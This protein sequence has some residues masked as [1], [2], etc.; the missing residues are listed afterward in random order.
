MSRGWVVYILMFVIAAGG[1][2]VILILGRAA[3][4]PDDLSGNWTVEW[5]TAPPPKSDPPGEPAR[6]Q[7]AHSGRFFMVQF[8]E[9]EPLR[10]TLQP[11]WRGKRIGRLL[12]MKLAGGPWRLDLHG[13][14]PAAER[15]RVPE[16][17]LELVGPTRHV[18][19][20]RREPEQ[21]ADV[22]P[23]TSDL[24]AAAPATQP[25]DGP[26]IQPTAPTA[27]ATA[28]PAHAR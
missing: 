19:I 15:F 28:E 11:G 1:L 7:V 24:P 25:G 3:N 16:V 21:T 14:I 4:A 12:T 17:R 5:I 26:P 10:M 9:R 20:A 18:G 22:V 2:W 23:P 6:M 13:D 27:S 8:G